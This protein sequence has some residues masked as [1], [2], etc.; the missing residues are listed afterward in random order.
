MSAENSFYK[1]L[2]NLGTTGL[3]VLDRTGA[4]RFANPS[5]VHLLGPNR[6]GT[7]FSDAFHESSRAQCAFYIDELLHRNPEAGAAR[8]CG[9]AKRPDGTDLWLEI[10]GTNA[11]GVDAINGVVLS[12]TDVTAWMKREQES[13][14]R[15]HRDELTGLSN[16]FLFSDRIDQ[17]KRNRLAGSVAMADVDGFK[18]INDSYGHQVGDDLLKE[19]ARR[20][21]DAFPHSVT[22]AR[23]GGDE[24]A[25]LLPGILIDDATVLIAEAIRSIGG[26]V[27]LGNLQIDMPTV[28]VGVTSLDGHGND[29]LLA[30][31]DVAMY[32]AKTRGG[33]QVLAYGDEVS[34]FAG[35]RRDLSARIASLNERNA[36]LKKEARTDLLTGLP[37]YRA[38]EEMFGGNECPWAIGAVLFLDLDNFG[39]YNKL[40][41]DPGGDAALKT[42]GEAIGNS[43]RGSDLAYRKGGEEF[44]VV[45]PNA[46]LEIALAAGQRLCAAVAALGIPHSD[47][48]QSILTVTIGISLKT[49]ERTISY[50]IGEASKLAMAAKM[51]G[52]RGRVHAPL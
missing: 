22:L 41:T 12:V 36:I 17:A 50:C 3:V 51:N 9:Q 1:M 48:E 5:F 7:P 39:K 13:A 37:N 15:A 52:Q 45:L 2:V 8:F 6:L 35:T 10:R 18:T 31:C 40:Y 44:V 46:D 47:S 24:F 32:A 14:A 30:Q 20:L 29:H 16:R 33:N 27:K 19:F 49:A 4:I 42:V 28:S 21:E 34:D 43:C 11:F 38:L 26:K 25:M 23:I